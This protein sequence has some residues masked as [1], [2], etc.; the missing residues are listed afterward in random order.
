MR[1]VTHIRRVDEVLESYGVYPNT[2]SLEEVAR[3]SMWMLTIL[4]DINRQLRSCQ[5][6]LEKG[7]VTEPFPF[8]FWKNEKHRQLKGSAVEDD[9]LKY[10][11]KKLADMRINFSIVG[12]DI[13]E[14]KDFICPLNAEYEE[15]NDHLKAIEEMTLELYPEAYATYYQ[16]RKK[17]LDELTVRKKY[18]KMKMDYYPITLQKLKTLQA[19]VVAD[20]LIA[21]I[22][23]YDDDTIPL[24]YAGVDV[25]RVTENLPENYKGKLPADFDKLCVKYHRH[26]TWSNDSILNVDY[27]SL[28]SYLYKHSDKF[29]PEQFV[30]IY[31]HDYLLYLV[32]QDMMKLLDNS[33]GQVEMQAPQDQACEDVAGNCFKNTS[34]FVR[35]LVQNLV[36]E[37]YLGSAVNLTLIEITLYDHNLIKKRNTHTAFIK[38]L[39]AWGIITIDEGEI[40]ALANGMAD[41]YKRIPKEGYMVWPYLYINDKK[42]CEDMGRKLGSTIPYSRK[43]DE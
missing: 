18:M 12:Y 2:S 42:M 1:L 26:V 32:R 7:V 15:M 40:K 4:A 25:R 16:S 38:S 13:K 22:M 30:A 36:N 11:N 8:S 28:G 6:E 35:D 19:Q 33:A 9:L 41:K 37:Y 24:E 5:E 10:G 29:T 17:E 43:T 27:D 14:I 3:C 23:N 20:A 21:G 39:I 31:E 34:G